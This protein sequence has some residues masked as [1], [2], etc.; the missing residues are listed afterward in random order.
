[1][2]IILRY[3]DYLCTAVAVVDGVIATA[4]PLQQ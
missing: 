2:L 4:V 3:Q 1:M